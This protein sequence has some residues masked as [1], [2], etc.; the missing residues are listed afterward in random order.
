MSFWLSISPLSQAEQLVQRSR[1]RCGW[2]PEVGPSSDDM[3]N[4]NE[5]SLLIPLAAFGSLGPPTRI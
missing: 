1:K 2:T 4:D 3:A 5:S